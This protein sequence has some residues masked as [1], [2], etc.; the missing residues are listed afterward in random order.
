MEQQLL[1]TR[2]IMNRI[3]KDLCGFEIPI[4]D[5]QIIKKSKG[6]P[7]Y[8]E[9]KHAALDKLLN[10]L[11]LTDKDILYD[12]GSGVGK[13][14]LHCAMTTPLK[15]AIGVELS[16]AR[17]LEAEIAFARACEFNPRLKNRAQF[18]NQDLMTIDLTNATV[19]YMCS[20]AFSIKF[21]NEV[22]KRLGQFKHHFRLV[23]LQDLPTQK[24]FRL[25]KVLRLDMSWLRN[26]PVHIYERV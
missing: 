10:Y 24:N 23:S 26:T 3:Y 8:G 4:S 1:S 12:L 18:V 22:C 25:I 6:S 15:K 5:S 11:A 9:I 19:I 13:V 14:V 20:T 2:K 17:H 7:V 16:S 21:M